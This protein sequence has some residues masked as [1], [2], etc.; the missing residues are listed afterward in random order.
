MKKYI[1]IFLILTVSFLTYCFY[2]VI[3]FKENNI[4]KPWRILLF[5]RN[6]ILITDKQTSWGYKEK[7]IKYDK[8]SKLIQ[9]IIQIED[10]NFYNHFWINILSKLRAL[11]SNILSW[12]IVSGWS[13]ITE[14]YIKNKYF[15]WKKRNFL[16]KTREITLSF[17]FS[18][19]YSKDEILNNYLNNV[20]L[21]NN[22]YWLNWASNVFFNKNDL[23][24]LT[25]E[26]ITILISLI[27]NPGIKSLKERN[28]SFYFDEVKQ[29]L[30]FN[31]EKTIFSLN[32]KENIDLFPF[33]TNKFLENP[34]SIVIFKNDDYIRVSI[35][36]KLQFFA[37]EELNQMIIK[38]KQNNVTNWAIFAINPK[39]NQILIYQGSRDFNE[40]TI[41]WQVDVIK[42]KRQPGSTM[43]PFLYL[44]ALE[45]WANIDDLI[46][47]IES[48]YNSFQEWKTYISTNYSLKEYWI[49]RFKKALWNS[50]NNASVRLASELWL[51]NVYNFYK[52]YWFDLPFPSEHYWYS[53]VLWNPD[54]TL[55]N[56]VMSYKNLLP[57]K[58]DINKFLLYDVLKDPDNRDISFW[59]N[60][61]LNTSIS[62]AVKTWTSSDFRDNL[63]VSYNPD[64]I[65]WIWI[66]NN[67]NSSMIWVTWITWA[68][69]IWHQVIEKAIELWYIVDDYVEIP[70]WLIKWDYCLDQD[71]FRKEVNYKKLGKIYHSKIADNIY[72]SRDLFEKISNYEKERIY[73]FWFDL[74]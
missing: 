14:Q 29:K 40:K 2:P 63:I 1:I 43:K 28:F 52:K 41:D 69:Y 49:V 31:F 7:D 19:Y 62:Q 20:Y 59:V 44:L 57:N 26:E 23:S 27:N 68:W 16:Q 32:K 56:L 39:N 55:E 33:V 37:K 3:I 36:S 72:D 58:I 15:I 18:F 13:T 12:K 25:E 21:G 53:L 64:F 73:D 46:I 17:F 24:N 47:D 60:S 8:N 10:K 65:I 22:I 11:K 45:N 48:E 74:K 6:W 67:D 9:S 35:D 38:L 66:G 42:S 71:C 50:F 5:D 61:V 51:E 54:I 30:N 70:N 34:K 4:N